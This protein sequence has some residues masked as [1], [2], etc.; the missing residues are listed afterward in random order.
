MVWQAYRKVKA[1]KG[2]SGIDQMTWDE[3]DKNRVTLLYKLWNRMSSGSYFPQ[4]V[5]EVSIKKKDGGERKLGIP[6]L[7]DRIAQEVVRSYLEP[8]VEPR[9]HRSSYGYR[10]NRD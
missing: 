3:L 4:P 2:S 6:T 5:K 1:N 7:L 10:P 8:K 9:F